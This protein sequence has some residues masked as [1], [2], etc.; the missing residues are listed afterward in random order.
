[1]GAAFQDSTSFVSAGHNDCPET[2]S[3]RPEV[4]KQTR[5]QDLDFP[6][7][8]IVFVVR[9][10]SRY[11]RQLYEPKVWMASMAR[12]G[13]NAAMVRANIEDTS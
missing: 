7:R 1:M 5:R 8:Y 2:A 9:Y 10:E 4:L 12:I 13:I 6:Y 3:E 11:R